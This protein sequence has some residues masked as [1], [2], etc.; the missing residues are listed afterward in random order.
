MRQTKVGTGTTPAGG[1]SPLASDGATMADV[2]A[3]AGVSPMTVSRVLNGGSASAAAKAAV[4]EAIA[5]LNYKPNQAARRLAISKG[6][7]S[8]GRRAP[9]APATLN[10]LWA[11]YN[12]FLAEF[13]KPRASGR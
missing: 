7:K 13:L 8:S 12:D 9:A 1:R 5:R 4:A 11:P 6:A 3:V 2:A 10:S